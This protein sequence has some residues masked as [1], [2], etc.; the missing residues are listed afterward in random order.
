MLASLLLAVMA[1]AAAPAP[2]PSASSLPVIVHT[3]TSRSCT[4]LSDT[5]MPIG[6]VLKKDD[7]AFGGMSDRLQKIF[8]D[9]ANQGGGPTS[10]QLM[11]LGDSKYQSG[12]PDQKAGA[13]NSPMVDTGDQNTNQLF[14]PSQTAKAGEVDAIANAIYGNLS[15]ASQV[16]Q[17]SIGALPQGTDPKADE[18]RSRAQALMTLQHS[19]ADNYENFV[20][21]YVSN[22]NT[23]WV[24][25]ADQRAFVNAYLMALITGKAPSD[26]SL[27]DSERARIMSIVDAEQT[28]RDGEQSFGA[29]L[30]ETYNQCNGTHID[31]NATPS[32]NP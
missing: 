18:M 15:I 30:I 22:Q 23:A 27:P 24:G 25:N 11:Q 13:N 6:Y 28:L 1:N 3:I 2:L 10:Q 26:K 8:S 16:L 12:G 7:Q 14:S 31:I 32:P 21:N 5:I 19:F 29:E 9:F 20:K 4:T 17:K